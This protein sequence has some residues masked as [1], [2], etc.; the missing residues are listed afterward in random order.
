MT[1]QEEETARRLSD[2]RAGSP[3]AL[4][5]VLEAC[6]GYLLLIA[7]QEISPDLQ[8]KAGASDLVQQT[9]LE[10]QCDSGRFHGESVSE[11]RAWLRR[12]LLNNLATFARD[13]RGTAKRAVG[14]EVS[15][16]PAGPARAEAGPAADAP[17][18]SALAVAREEAE[19]LRRVLGRLPEDYQRAL[20]LRHL[21]ELPF[22]EIGRRLGRTANGARKLWARAVEMLHEEWEPPP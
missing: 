20:L 16:P 9:C 6:R 2:A 22:E 19:A 18:P 10:A 14:R 4:G 3:E 7:R 15:L 1:R 17:S 11:L 13:Y 5:A 21:E 8:A 12:L